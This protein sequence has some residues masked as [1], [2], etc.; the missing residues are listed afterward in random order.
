MKQ[1]EVYPAKI[2][3]FSRMLR[4]EGLAV[5]P[6]ETADACRVLSELGFEDRELVK[7]ALRTVYAKSREEQKTFDR[8]FD[9]FFISEDRMRAQAR[10]QMKREQELEEA[11]Q[12]A[13]K[14]LEEN[15][16]PDDLSDEEMNAYVAMS[17]AE[18]ERL[19]KV[20][21]RYQKNRERQNSRLYTNF[22]HSVFAKSIM[23]QQMKMEDAGLGVEAQDP[24]TGILY[25]DI[26]E[27]KESDIPKATA[28]IR[29]LSAQI[30][31]ERSAR[32]K[33]IG[34]TGKPDFR[35]TIRKG[36]ESGGSF[37]K[38]IYRKNRRRRKKLVVLCDVSGSMIQFS[39]FVLRLI[40][41]LGQVSD[42][43]RIFLFS[44]ETKEADAFSLQNMD[45]FR[46]Y[47]KSSGLYGRGTDLGT[48]LETILSERPPALG[49]STTLLIVSDAKTVDQA[50]AIRDLRLARRMA[51]QVLFLNPIPESK[52]KYLSSSRAFANECPMMSISNLKS[53][54]NAVRKLSALRRN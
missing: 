7:D 8:V 53:L 9:G 34:D 33:R 31:G 35:R 51:G 11:K 28:M 16:G 52:W 44:E 10:E 25:R 39:E 42:S 17:E 18:R 48:A 14:E 13:Q 2:A 1:S 26:S 23:E 40:L 41:E 43:S 3:A 29:S 30:N 12:K 47:V 50:R 32:K 6:S 4:K 45:K 49:Q 38:I 22:I 20:M 36:L 19:R 24:E 27:M 21:D 46:D 54:G 15:G 37:A 5:G